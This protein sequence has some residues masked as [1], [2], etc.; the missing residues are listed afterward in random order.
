MSAHFRKAVSNS[1]CPWNKRSLEEKVENQPYSISNLN[2]LTLLRPQAPCQP[3]ELLYSQ[4][5][6]VSPKDAEESWNNIFQKIKV[7][8]QN[9][10]CPSIVF[11]RIKVAP[12]PAPD[13][14]IQIPRN[15]L[16][17]PLAY[18]SAVVTRSMLPT[19]ARNLP[20]RCRNKQIAFLGNFLTS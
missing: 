12:S 15:W 19:N 1:C 3:S 10:P 4:V 7:M 8:K 18:G 9:I 5:A 17:F 6:D 20:M 13:L 14:W 11:L 16:V 2:T